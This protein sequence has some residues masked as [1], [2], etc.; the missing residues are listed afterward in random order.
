MLVSRPVLPGTAQAHQTCAA[1]AIGVAS[2]CSKVGQLDGTVSGSQL[3]YLTAAVRWPSNQPRRQRH[4]TR[5]RMQQGTT[6]QS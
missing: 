3:S 2:R 5:L 6:L 1:D 4:V